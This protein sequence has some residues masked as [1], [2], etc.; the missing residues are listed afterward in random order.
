LPQIYSLEEAHSDALLPEN[1]Y[2]LSSVPL[3][4]LSFIRSR[5]LMPASVES[6]LSAV[7]ERSEGRS[8]KPIKFLNSVESDANP[9]RKLEVIATIKKSLRI[10]IALV[11]S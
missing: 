6:G 2:N 1:N 5:S 7:G 3:D 4:K 10:A 8:G 11:T 9:Q